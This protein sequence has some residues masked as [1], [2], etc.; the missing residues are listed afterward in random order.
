MLDPSRIKVIIYDCDGVLIDSLESNL[1]YYN[2]I[3]AHFALPPVS[4]QHTEV[5]HTGTARQVI[6][7]LFAGTPHLE[8]AQQFQ[9]T[10]PGNIFLHLIRA[11]PHVIEVLRSVRGRFKTAVAT[12]R[13]KSLVPVL[14]ELGLLDLFDVLVSGFDVRRSK[15]DP[16]CVKMILERLDLTPDYALYIGDSRVDEATARAAGVTFLSYKNPSL[17]AAFHLMDHRKLLESLGL[18]A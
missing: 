5:V 11:E 6:D 2:H 4:P 18:T 9:V 12:N 14:R 3:L 13:G 10:V 16:D 8:A 7:A 17:N 1:A 15:P